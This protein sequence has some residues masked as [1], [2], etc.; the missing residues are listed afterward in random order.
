[1][2]GMMSSSRQHWMVGDVG[3]APG[4]LDVGDVVIIVDDDGPASDEV[5]ATGGPLP[6]TRALPKVFQAL[7]KVVRCESCVLSVGL[8]CC[9]AQT[10][11]SACADIE[12]NPE[13]QDDLLTLL[14]EH[15]SAK[16]EDIVN[17][18]SPCTNVGQSK[19]RSR[20]P[21][22]AQ[23]SLRR[24]P[25]TRSLTRL[26]QFCTVDSDEDSG[27]AQGTS[28]E[29]ELM[30]DSAISRARA[31]LLPINFQYVKLPNC[32]ATLRMLV[33]SCDSRCF[34]VGATVDPVRRWLGSQYT[35]RGSPMPGHQ[36]TWNC[37]FMVALQL[38]ARE[39][40]TQLITFAKLHW[41][42]RCSNIAN[43]ARGQCRGAN[44]IYV[45]V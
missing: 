15:D 6:Q 38:R 43:D 20:S 11:H 32:I 29:I 37:M 25:S 5:S 34:Y 1:M 33:D 41:P 26:L 30:Y 7:P 17:I 13:P 9:C 22:G 3:P 16:A 8:G 36:D 14:L 23:R 45:C 12:P 10:S 18:V 31:L 39:L 24:A 35:D 44:W 21:Y 2:W 42:D 19:S 27:S 40:E 28:T 4:N